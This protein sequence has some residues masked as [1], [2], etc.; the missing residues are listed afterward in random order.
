MRF[1]VIVRVLVRIPEAAKAR[2]ESG[3]EQNGTYLSFSGDEPE[4]FC[5][6]ELARDCV[7]YREQARSHKVLRL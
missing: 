3:L 6:N 7:G 1:G 5:G 4:L 2:D